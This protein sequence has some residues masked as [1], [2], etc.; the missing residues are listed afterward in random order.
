MNRDAILARLAEIRDEIDTI[1]VEAA[2]EPTIERFDALT[3]EAD[4]LKTDL[5]SIEA[6]DA[7]RAE[8][9]AAVESG[10]ARTVPATDMR[11]VNVNVKTDPYD[12]SDL[13]AYGSQ[14]A[15]EIRGR[16]LDVIA[17]EARFVSDEHRETATKLIERI[18]STP[19]VAEN[20]LLRSSEKYANAFYKMMAGADADLTSEERGAINQVRE[21]QRAM[22][23][24]DVTGVLV[25]SQLDPTVILSND[26]ATNPFRAVSRVETGTTNVYTTVSS[27]GVTASWDAEGTE[28]SDDAPSFSNPTTTAFKAN[29]FVPISYEAF[30]DLRGREGDIL[31]L[32]AD[33]KDRLEAT[34]FATGNGSSAP[35][36]IV[37]ALDA[38]TNVEVS[39][40]TSNVF[41]VADVYTLMENLPARWRANAT[42]VA[43]LAIINDIRQFGTDS[44]N[45]QTVQLGARNVPAVLGHAILESSAMDGSIGVAGTDNILVV[46]D[47]SQ[48]LIYDRLGLSV[49]FVPNL[50][51]TTNARPTGQRGW[52][53]HWRTGANTQV[54]TAFRLLQAKT[55]S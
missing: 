6:R 42:W 53:A 13:P 29:A 31:R 44:Y 54:D 21:L 4:G 9:R 35:R 1:D 19:N 37:T 22:A 27:A 32:I 3:D 26:G 15:A 12:L 40:A 5:E 16:A 38:N 20:V 18:G 10:E 28:V 2:D 46:G 39:T 45:T 33:S 7:K 49:E 23:L 55:N 14:R 30:E 43:N 50:F 34:A 52:M 51:G 41:A 24:S 8:V 48:Y 47:F 36:G 25:P 17:S 11:S